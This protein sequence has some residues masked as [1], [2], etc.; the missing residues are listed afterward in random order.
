MV[1]VFGFFLSFLAKDTNS[2]SF[3]FF[4]VIFGQGYQRWKFLFFMDIFGQGY[5]YRPLRLWIPT[6]KVMFVIW[7]TSG[8]PLCQYAFAGGNL[9]HPTVQAEGHALGGIC[10]RGIGSTSTLVHRQASVG[11]KVRVSRAPEWNVLIAKYQNPKGVLVLDWL[12][13]MPV[14]VDRLLSL[15]YCSGKKTEIPVAQ[16]YG[17]DITT[18]TFT[19]TLT[20]MPCKRIQNNS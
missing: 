2:E 16:N 12:L 10:W 14:Q 7:A 20:K 19:I 13:P 18:A 5:F 4:L 15:L 17:W 6:M 1:K 9:W 11:I 3:C 8:I